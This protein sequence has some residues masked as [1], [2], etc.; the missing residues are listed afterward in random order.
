MKKAWKYK[1]PVIGMMGAP[2]S[3]KS[4]VAHVLAELG[5]CVIDADQLAKDAINEQRVQEELK[6]WWGDDV[7]GDDGLVDR[8]FVAKRVFGDK[9]NLGRLEGVVHPVVGQLREAAREEAFADEG[10]KAVVEDCP[11]LLEVGLDVECDV[12]I[13]VDASWES[14]LKRVQE[15]RGWDEAE[16]RKREKNQGSLDTKR[17]RADYVISN[18][19]GLADT[20]AEVRRFAS[21]IFPV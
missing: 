21:L 5:C 9:A 17:R 10:V 2:G 20:E 4:V 18:D 19:A 16:L 6:A 15:N 12:L 1:K 13:Y 14:R 11:L 3:G 7:I 8:A